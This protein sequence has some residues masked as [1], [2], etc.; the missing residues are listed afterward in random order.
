MCG[1]EVIAVHSPTFINICLQP[2]Y[3]VGIKT[4]QYWR[5]DASIMIELST[6]TFAA[7]GRS[8]LRGFL[9]TRSAKVG[10]NDFGT[11][12]SHVGCQV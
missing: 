3:I 8:S 7:N 1:G 12:R 6:V 10:L 2:L 9:V 11:V 5:T 4:S